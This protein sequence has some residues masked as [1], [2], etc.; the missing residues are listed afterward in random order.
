MK[1]Y[2]I[3]VM[4]ETADII[5]RAEEVGEEIFIGDFVEKHPIED[6]KPYIDVNDD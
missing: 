3:T 4:D 2:L 6:I 1:V 5:D